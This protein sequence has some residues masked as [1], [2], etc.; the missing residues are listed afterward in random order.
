MGK[1]QEDAFFAVF[2]RGPRQALRLF[3]KY[4]ARSLRA[5]DVAALEQERCDAVDIQRLQA[6]GFLESDEGEL[7]LDPRAERFL[8]DMLQ[9][10][11]GPQLGWLREQLERLER[12]T[13]VHQDKP[14][15]R[16]R[17]AREIGR[18]LRSCRTHLRAQVVDLQRAVDYDFR[19]EPQIEAK[20]LKLQWHLDS[21][22]ALGDLVRTLGATL[23]EDPFFVT[24]QDRE[25]LQRRERLLAELTRAHESLIEALQRISDYL[26][27]VRRDAARIRKLLRLGDLIERMEFTARTNALQVA[28]DLE[29]PA[30]RGMSI[31]SVLDPERL[32]E[33]PDWVERVL[34]RLGHR[35]GG[36]KAERVILP[37]DA[38]PLDAEPIIDPGEVLEAF[39]RQD[40][41]L[42]AFLSVLETEDGLLTVDQVVTLY[43]NLLSNEQAGGYLDIGP[44]KEAGAWAYATVDPHPSNAH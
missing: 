33:H 17:A 14:E 37:V 6:A 16:E 23:R 10:G 31:H 34:K 29:G 27:R 21:C 5:D 25:V 30:L 15:L 40:K 39:R 12:W 44:M 24:T 28:D 11:D 2:M 4:R 7:C 1:T 43:C 32:D 19:T 38:E 9:A 20:E 3:F 36:R 13:R 22:Q 26:N 41:D 18:I 8:E 35:T 42:F